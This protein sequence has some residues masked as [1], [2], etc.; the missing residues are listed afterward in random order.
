[1]KSVL[2][3][4]A[5]VALVGMPLVGCNTSGTS[6]HA[7]AYDSK[8]SAFGRDTILTHSTK[9][10][11]VSMKG[12]SSARLLEL[13]KENFAL[14]NFGLSEKYFR[15]AVA[16]RSDN[17]S[18]WAGLAASYDQLGN[19]DKAD[20]AYKALVD[21]KGNDPR[22][23]NNLGYSHLLRGDY[24]KAR[25]YFNRAQNANPGLEHV[26]GNLHLLEKVISS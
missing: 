22:V 7:P 16:N 1:M 14:Q 20:R 2:K 17:A 9:S 25:S 6:S 4:I 24:K 26:Q 21:I 3:T 19:F 18:A 8:P 12:D 13:G 23:L 15:E 10:D 11:S 5:L